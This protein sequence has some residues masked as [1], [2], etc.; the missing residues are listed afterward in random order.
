MEIR[1]GRVDDAAAATALWTE[2]Y[3]M[4]GPEGRRTPYVE[5]EYLESFAR[6]RVLIAEEGGEVLGVVV[7]LAPGAA[8]WAAAEEAALTRLVV[9]GKARGRGIG[10]DLAERCS[11]EARAAGAATIVLWSRPYQV[12]AH[13]LYESLGYRHAPD[14]DG[15]DADGGRRIFV[16][17]LREG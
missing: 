13:R 12:G 11:A 3:T 14:R 7:F 16:L 9:S 2:G 17:D 1:D 8:E 15:S 4:Q 6:G 5:H 10:R